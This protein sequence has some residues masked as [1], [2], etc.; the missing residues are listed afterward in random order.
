[1]KLIMKYL[2]KYK[3]S[4]VF[5]FILVG[6]SVT[7]QLIQPTIMSDIIQAI[8]AND[9]D[10]ITT[11]GLIMIGL[12]VAGFAAGIINT[13]I[14]ARM[15]QRTGSDIRNDVFDKVQEFSYSNIEKFSA[16][17]LVV[18]LVNDSQQAQSLVMI[19]LQSL[20]RIPVMFV[21]SL[22]LAM[23]AMP[24]LW[25]IVLVIMFLVIFMV[26]V[27]FGIMGPKFGRMQQ[28]IEKINAI[29][30]EN[31]TGMRVV[32]SFVQEDSE[33]EK[34]TG[35][36]KRL[37]KEIIGVGFVFSIL[38]PSF[39][40]IMDGGSAVIMMF[41][42]N[43]TN[44]TPAVL[45]NA[46][47]FINYIVMIMMSLMIGGMMVSFSS[48]AF[49][50]LKRIQEVL[51]TEVDMTY[52][53][54]DTKLTS[55]SIKFENVSFTYDELDHP[56]LEDINFEINH[57]ETLGIVG[58][59]GSG[60]STL[61]Q[62]I[63]RIYDPSTGIVTV[64]NHDL[65][66]ISEDEL[67]KNV[68]LVLQ[69]PTLFSGTIADNIRQ[70]KKDA[71]LE[72]MKHAAAIAQA[73]E[74]IEHEKDGFDAEVFQRGANFSGGQKQRI[75]IARGIVGNPNILILDDSTSALDAKSEKNVKDALKAEMGQTTKVIV[76]QKISSVVH[77]DKIL[78]LDE[79]RLVQQGTHRELLETSPVYQEIYETQK[80]RAMLDDTFLTEAL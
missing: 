33:I 28:L 22:I 67:R 19:I 23:M 15:A 25:W 71:T 70:G 37:T 64:D 48:R 30:K 57:G 6:I 42:G 21:G 60:K 65:K 34:F 31:F 29:A 77:A 2:K 14:A 55:G 69:R 39:F 8:V 10:Q 16:S 41:I 32:K 61:V 75:S 36:S 73:M 18:R 47:K 1:M 63:A 80:G 20:T 45:G 26:M 44:L 46:I 59:T 51:D 7:S 56:T 74:F 79:G 78:V 3:W 66:T 13:I 12:A 52:E 58:A 5:S 76:S 38:M 24:E 40:L 4:I 9:T 62:L 72:E 11:Q 43:M 53:V 35:E 27:S 49:V 68:S 17:N 50:S 54:N